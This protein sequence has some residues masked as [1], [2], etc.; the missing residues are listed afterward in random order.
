MAYRHH[1]QTIRRELKYVVSEAA[2]SSVRRYIRSYLEP[3]EHMQP[4]QDTGYPV[5][6]FYLDT[7]S[8]ALY[9][10][11]I[12]GLKNRFKLRLRFYD[13]NP[14]SPIFLEIKRRVAEVICKERAAIKRHAALQMLSWGTRPNPED[15]VDV[16]ANGND[17]AGRALENFCRLRA[18][19]AAQV[20]LFVAYLREAYTSPDSDD[21]RVTFDREVEGNFWTDSDGIATPP[22]GPQPRIGGVILELKFTDRF[23]QWMRDLV[24]TYSLQPLPVSKYVHCVDVV[25][26]R[27]ARRAMSSAR[28][29]YERSSPY[30]AQ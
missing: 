21:V 26:M 16:D 19:I 13:R 12:D 23:P 15:L 5:W 6:S 11:T 14:D 8:L 27:P 3:D 1:P 30:A 18:S 7:P 4:G 22:P 9:R 10:Q 24:R 20:S 25:G 17:H 28:L 29:F 2:A